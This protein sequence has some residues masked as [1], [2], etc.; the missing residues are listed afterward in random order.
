MTIIEKLL[1]HSPGQTVL[2]MCDRCGA[3][4]GDTELHER[5]HDLADKGQPAEPPKNKGGRPPKTPVVETP[6]EWA[7]RELAQ[8][9]DPTDALIND[10][11]VPNAVQL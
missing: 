1:N 7:D 6:K 3:L 4:I 11:N 5:A 8:S 9:G 10:P 2:S